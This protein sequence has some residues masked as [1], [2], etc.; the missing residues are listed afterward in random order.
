MIKI[1]HFFLC[2]LLKFYKKIRYLFTG[3]I[4]IYPAGGMEKAHQNGKGWRTKLNNLLLQFFGNKFLYQNPCSFELNVCPVIDGYE[5]HQISHFKQ[6]NKNLEVQQKYN[7][8]ILFYDCL[9]VLSA[10]F[11]IAKYDHAA[12]ASAG[13]KAEMC[14]AHFFG[15]PVYTWCNWHTKHLPGWIIASSNKIFRTLNDLMNYV[16]TN[17]EKFALV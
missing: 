7:S 9:M 16:K 14:I 6:Q 11:I 17:Y 13:T 4:V 2:K 15:I 1:S 12:H 8:K 3:K 5:L 10:D